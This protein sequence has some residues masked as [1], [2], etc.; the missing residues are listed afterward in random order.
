MKKL[1]IIIALQVAIIAALIC[2]GDML[3]VMY[4]QSVYS[5]A[6]YDQKVYDYRTNWQSR[7]VGGD[8]AKGYIHWY[9]AYIISDPMHVNRFFEQIA[10]FS[11]IATFLLLGVAKLDKW[12]YLLIYSTAFGAIWWVSFEVTKMILTK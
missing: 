10:I 12:Y 5:T 2:R 4:D 1:L 8:H 6:K 9:D 11:L 7:Y 3:T